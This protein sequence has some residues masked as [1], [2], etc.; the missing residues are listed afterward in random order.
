MV[1]HITFDAEIFK[2]I[3][4]LRFDKLYVLTS[5]SPVR[6]AQ[7]TL[8]CYVIVLHGTASE[9]VLHENKSLVLSIR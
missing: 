3:D 9:T 6:I 8:E 7:M 4:T 5:G 2:V 1:R